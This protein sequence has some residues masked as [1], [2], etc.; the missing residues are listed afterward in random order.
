MS[1]NEYNYSHADTAVT[2]FVTEDGTAYIKQLLGLNTLVRWCGGGSS[3]EGLLSLNTSL[4]NVRWQDFKLVKSDFGSDSVSMDYQIYSG[5]LL[6]RCQ[7][8][9]CSI[10]GI[11]SRRDTL[12][13]LSDADISIFRCLSKF[14]FS[15][16]YYEVY[17]QS[18]NRKLESQGLW[19]QLHHGGR[20]F[21]SEG[22]FTC[23]GSTPFLGLRE[24]GKR[25]GIAFHIIPQGNWRIYANT[26]ASASKAAF[27][28]IEAGLSDENLNMKLPT[29]G[30]MDLPEILIHSLPDGEI[31]LGMPALHKYLNRLI[32]DSSHKKVPVVYN[33][34]YDY[35]DNLN[36]NRL[37]EQLAAAKEIGCDAF[38]IDA[39]WYGAGDGDWSLQVGDW[40]EKQKASFYGHMAEFAEEVRAGGM[41][42]GLWIE[43]E[44]IGTEAPILKEHPEWFLPSVGP[45]FY[46]N[47]P[48][49]KVY[50]YILGEMCRL[51]ETYHLVWMKVDF[52]LELGVDPYSSEYHT[53]YSSWNSLFIELRK[54]YPQVYFEGCA[55]G[56]LRLDIN[57]QMKYD[58]YWMSDN[59]NP[60]DMLSIYQNTILRTCPGKI[61]KWA[62]LRSAAKA[63]PKV[64]APKEEQ[65]PSVVTWTSSGRPWEGFVTTD[66]DFAVRS[67]LPGV[68]GFSGDIA[69]LSD[70]DRDR[71]R[72][73]VSFYKKWR[74]FIVKSIAHL[75]TSPIEIWKYEGWTTIQLQN[76]E[77]TT[78]LLFVYRL[79]DPCQERTVCLAGLQPE[80]RYT[81][82]NVDLEEQTPVVLSGRQLMQEGI[83]VRLGKK[84]SAGVLTVIPNTDI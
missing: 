41:G 51:I 46:P 6:Y 84:N 52:N 39:G 36:I 74:D 17:S 72:Y 78:S 37:R 1:T 81:V 27:T 14:V 49:E 56:G 67:A 21:G 24:V 10:T 66:L 42:F 30:S 61:T 4:G 28:V 68:L 20:V 2:T 44:R 50:Q 58:G 25:R 64:S 83:P 47:L 13:N 76:S 26:M 5:K 3:L 65:P 54:Q 9:L 43:P 79:E 60:L 73:H 15:P 57:N 62:V 33:T 29:G 19:Q 71:L 16:G 80:R 48:D 31:H 34:W 18:G 22:G 45:F 11:W 77:D 12:I 82:V 53:Y 63:Y 23:L 55:G 8:N 40:R 75:S 38:V 59:S 7:W 69:G 35:W 32:E 70:I